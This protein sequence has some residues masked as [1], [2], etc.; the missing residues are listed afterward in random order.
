MKTKPVQNVSGHQV[1]N[2][3]HKSFPTQTQKGKVPWVIK[4][5]YYV[6][7]FFFF[8]LVC[9]ELFDSQYHRVRWLK[10]TPTDFSSR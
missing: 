4:S 2:Y 8:L 7:K 9:T 6:M 5:L 3:I 1:Q 10:K